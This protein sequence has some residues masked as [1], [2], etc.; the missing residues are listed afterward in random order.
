MPAR[1]GVYTHTHTQTRRLPAFSRLGRRLVTNFIFPKQRSWGSQDHHRGGGPGPRCSLGIRLCGQPCLSPPS[2]PMNK[3]GR[4]SES[5]YLVAVL[6][7]FSERGRFF[8]G[9]PAPRPESGQ[10]DLGACSASAL[11]S[12]LWSV[13]VSFQTYCTALQLYRACSLSPVPTHSQ[14]PPLTTMWHVAHVVLFL[15]TPWRALPGGPCGQIFPWLH[16][17]PLCMYRIMLL[18]L[19]PS[20]FNFQKVALS[21]KDQEKHLMIK[22]TNTGAGLVVQWAELLLGVPTFH[23]GVSVSS[24]G[25]SAF[26]PASC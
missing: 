14:P 16:S 17:T 11:N 4:C 25:Y 2:T 3:P 10:K 1:T 12:S 15:D 21:Q 26:N 19:E 18:Y 6:T 24:P 5:L 13:S 9:S 8:S 23:I 20:R 7:L 22:Y